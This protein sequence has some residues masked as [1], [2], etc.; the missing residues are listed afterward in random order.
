MAFPK[1]QTLMS[2][3]FSGAM[4]L[5]AAAP[6]LALAQDS[7]ADEIAAADRA[8]SRVRFTCQDGGDIIA[9][10]AVERGELV[11]IVDAFDG[12][13]PHTL[14][15]RPYGVAP[16]R[17]IWSDGQHTLTWSAGVQIMW[18]DASVHRMCGRAGGHHH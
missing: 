4:L 3:I 13:G 9:K 1:S 12:D 5:A 14:A 11:A 16:V 18:M 10:F 8:E 6:G 7:D 17:L 2:A 15:S